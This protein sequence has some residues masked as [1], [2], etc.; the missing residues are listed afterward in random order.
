MF[1]PGKDSVGKGEEL[2]WDKRAYKTMCRMGVNFPC[3]SFDIISDNLGDF[4]TQFPAKFL[5]V[6]GENFDVFD[7][8]F[9]SL[10]TGS[11]APNGRENRISVFFVN[12]L[13]EF[14][15][16]EDEENFEIEDDEIRMKISYI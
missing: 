15:V 5:F 13:D 12:E 2:R 8:F 16:D 1:R 3:L 10:H 11:Q 6:G 7:V 14:E 4:R 9:E